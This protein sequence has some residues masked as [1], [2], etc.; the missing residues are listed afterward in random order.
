MADEGNCRRVVGSWLVDADSF[1]NF[2]KNKANWDG[3]TQ[4]HRS[5][6]DNLATRKGFDPTL[7]PTGWYDVTYLDVYKSHVSS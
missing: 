5:F 7:E 1:L 3:N 2:F 6:F 4:L